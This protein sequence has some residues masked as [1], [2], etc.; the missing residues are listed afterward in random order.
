MSC[1]KRQISNH[2]PEWTGGLGRSLH[3][4][5][6]E[7]HLETIHLQYTSSGLLFSACIIDSP[8][9][10][11]ILSIFL[12]RIIIFQFLLTLYTIGVNLPRN[13]HITIRHIACTLMYHLKLKEVWWFG[14]S[15]FQVI[16]PTEVTSVLGLDYNKYHFLDCVH[17]KLQ[18]RLSMWFQPRLRSQVLT[19]WPSSLIKI[20]ITN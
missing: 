5:R 6:L 7:S 12:T 1:M 15:P 13:L 14:I 10:R 18:Q 20:K 16:G 9:P 17:P 19:A 4:M 3:S 2:K 11:C 8:S